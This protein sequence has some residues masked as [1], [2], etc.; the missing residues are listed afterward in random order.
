MNWLLEQAQTFLVAAACTW[1]AVLIL[2][3]ALKLWMW[4]VDC[5]CRLVGTHAGMVEYLY[6]EAHKGMPRGQKR[7]WWV[8]FHRWPGRSDN[9]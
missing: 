2:G 3:S 9:T 8:R 6:I 1:A 5:F 4:V 7:R